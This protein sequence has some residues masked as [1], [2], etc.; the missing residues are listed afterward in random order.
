MNPTFD[1]GRANSPDNAAQLASAG[2]ST[3]DF[4]MMQRGLLF[5]VSD[6]C[7]DRLNRACQP[8]RGDFRTEVPRNLISIKNDALVSM[9]L[10]LT[11]SCG[12]MVNLK[13]LGVRRIIALLVGTFS[14]L[15]AIAFFFKLS[16]HAYLPSFYTLAVVALTHLDIQLA[17]TI[18]LRGWSTIKSAAL[19]AALLYCC[20][21]IHFY[22]VEIACARAGDL[23]EKRFLPILR[24]LRLHSDKIAFSLHA[25][26]ILPPQIHSPFQTNDA[27]RNIT[28]VTSLS[29][30]APLGEE[31]M[32]ARGVKDFA[33][34]LLSPN[35]VVLSDR[36]SNRL[37]RKYFKEHHSKEVR[38]T[39]LLVEQNSGLG[40][41]KLAA[42]EHPT[43]Q[44]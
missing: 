13:Q 39:G 27:L 8:Y 31:I 19:F 15:L 7:F 30:H 36:R 2:W 23:A 4:K 16:R 34:G 29:S 26:G 44:H 18:P 41:Y 38:F 6:S 17:K 12:L 28:L 3:N 25:T 22:N 10:I 14:L 9:L 11:V 5:D 33:S 1:W 24:Y 42:A 32:R 35:S 40:V 37:L 20:I 43:Q 21:T